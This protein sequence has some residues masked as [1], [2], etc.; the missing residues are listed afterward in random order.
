[1]FEQTATFPGGV[2]R[3]NPRRLNRLRRFLNDYWLI[4]VL[5]CYLQL[6]T[7]VIY[8]ADPPLERLYKGNR[9]FFQGIPIA[10]R[11][12]TDDF[13]YTL[14][15]HLHEIVDHGFYK[16]NIH[17]VPHV[18]LKAAIASPESRQEIYD[19]LVASRE[20]H[21]SELGGLLTVSYLSTGP[22]VHLHEVQS[23]NEI[24]F[25]KL[26]AA[27][28]SIPQFIAFL[29]SKEEREILEKVGLDNAW[30]D[31][32]ISI[33]R[34]DRITSAVKER[35]VQSFLQMYG[36]LSDSRYLLSPYQFKEALGRIP[37]GEQFVGL[38]HFHNGMNEPPSEIDVEQSLR[39]RQ[40]VM[41]FSPK[42]WTL[43]DVAKQNMERV[44]IEI[45]KT[46]L[47]Q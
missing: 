18:D 11:L 21:Q 4:P 15:G 41:T 38:Y 2:D 47:L 27:A 28:G 46:V 1:M 8:S 7:Q 6:S 12:A 19:R 14:I 10:Y 34:S 23:L 17:Q 33:M 32:I 22:V 43:Y 29:S 24:Y 36:I 35:L 16:F 25:N 44:D 30:L 9:T 40:I 42:G 3:R 39:K 37:F 45:D 5:I 26:Q 20:H 13:P 31:N